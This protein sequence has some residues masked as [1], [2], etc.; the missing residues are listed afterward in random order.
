MSVKILPRDEIYLG[1]AVGGLGL[2]VE[3]SLFA[4]LMD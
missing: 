4:L 2:L 3:I 1:L